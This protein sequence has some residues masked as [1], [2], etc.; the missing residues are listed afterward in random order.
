MGMNLLGAS[1]S[2][3]KL[4]D[5]IGIEPVTRCLQN[6]PTSS[7]KPCHFNHSIENSRVSPSI[8][9]WLDVRKCGSLRVRSLRS[10]T[11]QTGAT[12]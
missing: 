4:L 11:L 1:Q 6:S 12:T 7:C 10:S 8:R 2:E 9:L 3:K 5:V